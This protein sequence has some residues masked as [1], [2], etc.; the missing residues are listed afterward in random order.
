MPSK[1]A[2]TEDSLTKSPIANAMPLIFIQ[3]H[4]CI[5]NLTT[6]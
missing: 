6:F 3:G 2:V 4:K 1:F 5:S